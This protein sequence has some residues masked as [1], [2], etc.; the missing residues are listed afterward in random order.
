MACLT[1][2]ALTKQRGITLLLFLLLLLGV[3]TSLFLSVNN[4]TS[5]RIARERNTQELLRQARDALVAWSA[6][7]PT[8]PGMLPCPEDPTLIGHPTEGTART[9]CNTPDRRIGRLPWRTLGLDAPLDV[10]GEQLWYVLSNGFR[11]APINS[12]SQGSLT[13]DAQAVQAI[14]ILIAPGRP[15]PGQNR[16]IPSASNPPDLTQYLDGTNSNGD[17]A[18][19]AIAIPDTINDQLLT[20]KPDDF[21]P[22]IEKRVAAEVRYAL[23]E[24]YCGV[25]NVDVSG[26]CSSSGG[27][28]FFPRPALFSDTSCLGVTLP[29]PTC[30]SALTGNAGRIPAT[31]DSAYPW[32]ASSLL[33]AT[34]STWFQANRWRE[35]V[36]YAV[37]P[38]CIDGTTNCSGTSYLTVQ[39]AGSADAQNIHGVIVVAGRHLGSNVRNSTSVADYLEAENA[40][41]SDNI[42]TQ[43]LSP[44]SGIAFNDHLITIP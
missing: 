10:D 18:F 40:V 42:F 39:R 5:S 33:R 36:Y 9:S 34:G 31:P 2:G 30:P 35:L 29:S 14:A 11:S 27:N 44:I 8:L 15:L 23:R 16:S 7:H 38:A 41:T 43:W 26:N 1:G 13:V 28:R 22:A 32:S 4:G 17:D 12:E 21:F 25:G 6:A 20:L 19:T 24:Y 3:A 37:A